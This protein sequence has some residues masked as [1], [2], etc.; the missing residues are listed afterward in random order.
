MMLVQGPLLD[1]FIEFAK[2]AKLA[3]TPL[4]TR[5]IEFFLREF[6]TKK[7]FMAGGNLYF[8]ASYRMQFPLNEELTTDEHV[9]LLLPQMIEIYTEQFGAPSGTEMAGYWPTVPF[10]ADNPEAKARADYTKSRIMEYNRITLPFRLRKTMYHKIHAI[11]YSFSSGKVLNRNA[12]DSD[13]VI[14][15]T[16]EQAME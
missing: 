1:Q 14:I 5:T 12:P 13:P 4:T 15:E 10:I 16:E 6:L 11:G 7:T 2:R 8:G 3:D 9:E